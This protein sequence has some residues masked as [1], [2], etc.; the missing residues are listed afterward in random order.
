VGHQETPLKK[1]HQGSEQSHR[2][3]KPT[4]THYLPCDPF[5]VF[6]LPYSPRE[7]AGQWCFLKPYLEAHDSV[8][9]I[10][11]AWQRTQDDEP[12]I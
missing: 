8:G 10:G 9:V 2:R 1:G 12:E 7:L 11:C 5:I 6:L 4:G 3:G